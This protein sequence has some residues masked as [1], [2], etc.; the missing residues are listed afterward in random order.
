[1][2]PIAVQWEVEMH[3]NEG[4]LLTVMVQF[5]FTLSLFFESLI[6]VLVRV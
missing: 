1:M 5:F 4:A 3:K 6:R 2:P